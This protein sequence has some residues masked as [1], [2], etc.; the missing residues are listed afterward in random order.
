MRRF[1]LF[2]L[3]IVWLAGTATGQTSPFDTIIS[4]GDIKTAKYFG[5]PFENLPLIYHA[6]TSYQRIYN[7][8]TQTL[9]GCLAVLSIQKLDSSVQNSIYA[10]LEEMAI[11]F[12]Q[13]GTPIILLHGFETLN[14]AEQLNQLP[15]PYGLTY[16]GDNICISTNQESEGRSVFNKKTYE[17]VNYKSETTLPI[18]KKRKRL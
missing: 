6:D 2:L 12:H 16:F 11:R 10:R 14:K 7:E 9:A 15:N 4:A 3:L 5:R 13:E 8:I 1:F 17:L 18:R